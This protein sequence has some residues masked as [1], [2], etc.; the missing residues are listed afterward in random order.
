[1]ILLGSQKTAAQEA[2]QV[3]RSSVDGSHWHPLG[4]R[5]AFKVPANG[6]LI[7]YEHAAWQVVG[8]KPCPPDEWPEQMVP[9]ATASRPPYLVRL[10]PAHLANHPDPV[11]AESGDEHFIMPPHF[12]WSV[13]TDPEHYPVCRSCGEPMPCREEVGRRMAEAAIKDMGRYETPG[14]CPA[15]GEVVTGRQKSITFAD[16]VV[17]PGGPPVTFH[18]RGTCHL[19]AGQYEKRWAAADPSRRLTLSCAGS[20]TNHN[21]GT[22]DCT[23]Y[24]DCPGP[25]A[26]HGSMGVCRCPD[27]HSRPWTWGRGCMPHPKARRNTGGADDQLF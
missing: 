15:C 6:T 22:Y 27:C 3:S 14:M 8:S 26:H 4:T 17:V 1:M 11:V 9:F 18:L 19:S 12:S 24:G 23:A 2:F 5:S 21:D 16:N 25:T 13:F 7:A 10:R 20:L